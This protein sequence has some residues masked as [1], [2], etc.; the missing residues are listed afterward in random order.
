[1][2][3]DPIRFCLRFNLTYEEYFAYHLVLRKDTAACDEWINQ[4]GDFSKKVFI[5]LRDKGLIIT[6]SLNPTSIS[7]VQSSLLSEVVKEDSNTMGE[8][9]WNQYPAAFPLSDGA[10]F[11]ARKGP[12]KQEVLKLYL[13]RID[14]N[15]EKHKYVL[16]QLR[17]YIKLV[18]DRKINGHRIH[19][20]ISNEMW[21]IISDLEAASR[22]EFKTDI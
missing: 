21:D 7:S 19:D 10:M 9:L 17:K 20:W 12:D 14:F 15:P 5:S 3:N 16:E 2:E 11:I 4:K 22:G 1:M 8:E 18:F 6:T 13:E